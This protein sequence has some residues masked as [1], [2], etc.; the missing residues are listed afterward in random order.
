MLLSGTQYPVL[1]ASLGG[2]WLVGRV[3]YSLGYYTGVAKKRMN[4]AVGHIGYLGLLIT[5][6]MVSYNLIKAEL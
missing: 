3:L 4:G 5:S 2:I 1:A 6:G